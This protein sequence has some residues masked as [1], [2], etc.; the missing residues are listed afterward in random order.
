M[1]FKKQ[2]A[3]TIPGANCK[4]KVLEFL[5]EEHSNE[6]IPEIL[7]SNKPGFQEIYTLGGNHR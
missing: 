6:N 7:S 1:N 4:S 3:G 5:A 2:P